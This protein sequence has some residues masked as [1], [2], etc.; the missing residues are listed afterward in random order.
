MDII[1]T[2]EYSGK[3]SRNCLCKFA[4]RSRA[5]VDLRLFRQ[6][7]GRSVV[8]IGREESI[9]RDYVADIRRGISQYIQ[10]HAAK[11]GSKN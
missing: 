1:S 3:L 11:R 9:L 8:P 7:Q 10:S 6:G 2:D 5:E 4:T